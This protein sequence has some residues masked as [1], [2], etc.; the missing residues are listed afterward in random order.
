MN[1]LNFFFD[2]MI[3]DWDTQISG[4]ADPKYGGHFSESYAELHRYIRRPG[5]ESDM[6]MLQPM[7]VHADQTEL[8]QLLKKGHHNVQLDKES[9]EKLWSKYENLNYKSKIES[10]KIEN[11]ELVAIVVTK[12]TG[13]YEINGNK[14]E[15]ES[16]IK[17]EQ[18]FANE[19]LVKFCGRCPFRQYIPSKPRKYGIKFWII[20][21]STTSYAFKMD[22]YKGK[23]T[24]ERRA[25]NLGTNVAI[26]FWCLQEK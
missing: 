14:F 18:Y 8:I 16:E 2:K 9:L 5:I 26:T 15:L 10:S 19:Q 7:D 4:K 24:N 12:I 17:S 21:D 25:S 20:C 11:G 3:T 22:I 13:S 6:H 23:E 1:Q